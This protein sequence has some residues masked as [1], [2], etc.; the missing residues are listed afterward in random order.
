MLLSEDAKSK[1]MDGFGGGSDA[2]KE[3]LIFAEN[4]KFLS[5]LLNGFDALED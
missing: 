5:E 4:S 2:Y 1:L 3:I